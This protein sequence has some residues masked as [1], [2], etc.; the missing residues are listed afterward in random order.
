LK[1][2]LLILCAIAAVCFSDR[3]PAQIRDAGLWAEAEGEF[4]LNPFWTAEAVAELRLHENLTEAGAFIA[5]AGLQRSLGERWRVG[6]GMRMTL[7]Q[8]LDR[9]FEFRNRAYA[10]VRYRYKMSRVDITGRLHYMQQSEGWLWDDLKPAADHYLRAGAELKWKFTS[11]IRPFLAGEIYYPLAFSLMPYPDKV[12]C[13]A[14]FEYRLSKVHAFELGFMWQQELNVPEPGIDYV[15][16][17]GYSFA[18]RW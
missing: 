6:C 9:T 5:E 17:V 12:R 14:G 8:Q 18:P 2:K 4:R 1:T 3:L 10:D 11:A 7:N 15:G 16:F 13:R